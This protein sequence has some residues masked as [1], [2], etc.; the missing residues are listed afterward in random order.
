MKIWK[1]DNEMN[2][3][4][5]TLFEDELSKSNGG[6]ASVGQNEMHFTPREDGETD[7]EQSNQRNGSVKEIGEEVKVSDDMKSAITLDRYLS[8]HCPILLRE[9]KYDYGLILFD[10]FHFWVE[11]DGFEKLVKE[12]WSEAPVDASNAML[13]L[14]KKLKYLKKK[15][16]AW[17]NDMRKNSKNSKLM[18]KAELSEFDSVIEKGDRENK[19]LSHFKYRFEIPQEARLNLNMEFSCKLTSIQ[20]SDLEIKVSEEE[21]KRAVWDCGVDKSLGPDRF[22]FGLHRYFWKLIETD[23]VAAMKYFFQYGSIPKGFNSS[24]IALILKIPDAKMVKDFR[25]ISLIE[26]LYKIIAKILANRLVVVPGDAVNE[27]QL[28]FVVDRQILD[29]PFILNELFQWCKSKKKHSFIFKVDFEK[30]YDSVHWDYLDDVLKFFGFGDRW[31]GWIQGCLRSSWG[32]VIVNGSPTEK[33]QFFKGLCIN[34]SKSKLMGIFVDEEKVDQATAKIR[35]YSVSFFN[36][37]D[38]GGKKSI[39]VKCN[40][41]LASKEKGGLGVSILYALNRALMFKWIWR[42]IT[43]RS[44]L[45]ARVIKAIHGDDGK[46]GKNLKR[47]YPSIWRDIVQ[48]MEVFKKQ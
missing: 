6:E 35:I 40:N 44:S 38:L 28:A 1:R 4:P 9:S 8:D 42:F 23:V 20:Q 26:S 5:D 14:M 46:I 3:I 27:A 33:F 24:F 41:V 34:M 37:A 48:E 10:F 22:N 39:W 21:I 45:W 32:S 2:A 17:N 25:P 7:V 36:G 13:N 11:V 19:F 12:T 47:R 30:A 31:C 16:R 15:I 18:F 29:G 43:Q